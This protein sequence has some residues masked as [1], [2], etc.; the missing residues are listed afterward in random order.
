[1]VKLVAQGKDVIISRTFSKIYGMAGL[2]LGYIVASK[3]DW[4]RLDLLP[5]VEW[6]S[7][8]QVLMLQ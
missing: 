1:M 7:Q 4:R 5:E 6:V 3:K 8:G 2:R